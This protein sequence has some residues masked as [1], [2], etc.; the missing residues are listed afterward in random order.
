VAELEHQLT[1][2]WTGRNAA[3]SFCYDGFGH[4]Q[5]LR[6]VLVASPGPELRNLRVGALE[7]ATR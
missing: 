2:T 6:T 3:Q 4:R 7:P 1:Q 5:P